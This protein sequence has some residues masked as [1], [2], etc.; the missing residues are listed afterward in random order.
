[1]PQSFTSTRVF[2]RTC[3]MA[4]IYAPLRA[5]SDIVF[6]GALVNYILNSRRWNSEPFFHDY[7]VHYTNAATLITGLPGPGR[8]RWPV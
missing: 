3:A 5:G 1:M 4:N 7:V 6:L 8:P 2:T